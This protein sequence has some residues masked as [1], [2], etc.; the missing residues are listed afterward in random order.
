MA[1]GSIFSDIAGGIGR[2][3]CSGIGGGGSLHG[4]GSMDLGR[5]SYSARRSS[6]GT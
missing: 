1:I 4:A 5:R 3:A 2:G 6:V